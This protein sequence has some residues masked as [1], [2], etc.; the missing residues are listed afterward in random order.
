MSDQ[1]MY[2]QQQQMQ[3][4]QMQQQQMMQQQQQQQQQMQ[5]TPEQ[6]M[7][8]QQYL[9]QQHQQRAEAAAAAIGVQPPPVQHGW[10]STPLPDVGGGG[11][12]SATSAASPLPPVQIPPPRAPE[13]LAEVVPNTDCATTLALPITGVIQYLYAL[14]WTFQVLTSSIPPGASPA[15]AAERFQEAL[16][17]APHPR[18]NAEIAMALQ[19]LTAG[20][21]AASLQG[22][23]QVYAALQS[24][25]REILHQ[26]IG[27]LS[28][29]SS[30]YGKE[31]SAAIVLLQWLMRQFLPATANLP[32]EA[33]YQTR[34][35]IMKA[36]DEMQPVGK[37]LNPDATNPTVVQLR[38]ALDAENKLAEKHAQRL[39]AL[40]LDPASGTVESDAAALDARTKTACKRPK[41]VV[42]VLGVLLAVVIII[43]IVLCIVLM[44]RQRQGNPTLMSSAAD[45]NGVTTQE[46]AALGGVAGTLPDFANSIGRQY[47]NVGASGGGAGIGVAASNGGSRIGNAG[48]ML[49]GERWPF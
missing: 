34:A 38:S 33:V 30:A 20:A 1:Q 42:I 18:T 6:Q 7:M 15:S 47:F 3:Q 31:G 45:R 14:R 10:S 44:K 8:H 26:L 21:N 41:A 48:G 32:E 19:D 36:A 16:R 25:Q 43:A 46:R 9:I 2:M 23:L 29:C 11:S 39:K 22:M 12:A 24:P 28:T 35:A 27:R 37:I 13:L 17:T 4:Q 49:E 40:A 5:M